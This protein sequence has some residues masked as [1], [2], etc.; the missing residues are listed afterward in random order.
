MARPTGRITRWHDR[1]QPLRRVDRW[2]AASPCCGAPTIRS[3]STWATGPSATTT[4]ELRDRLARCGPD[5]RV[6]GHR[7]RP[8]RVRD[9]A[10]AARDGVTFQLGGF[11]IPTEPPPR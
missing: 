5:V 4:L 1:H 2:I 6:V 9:A 7:D 10:A 8:Q 11:E 3:S